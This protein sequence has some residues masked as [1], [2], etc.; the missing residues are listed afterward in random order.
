[1]ASL[2][3][4]CKLESRCE[5]THGSTPS[6]HL[7]CQVPHVDYTR[8]SQVTEDWDRNSFLG[9]CGDGSV[10]KDTRSISTW[11]WLWITGHYIKSQMW[12]QYTWI[13]A[14]WGVETERSLGLTGCQHSSRFC[15]RHCLV[16]DKMEIVST[17]HS[18][19]FIAFCR[20]HRGIHTHIHM[21]IHHIYTQE[22]HTYINNFSTFR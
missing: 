14:L 16:R 4:H 7:Y 15:K 9:V 6:C 20:A 21:C 19:S 1:M 3:L 18:V 8:T 22:T 11:P 5:A 13:P 10:G 12:P 17:G 2:M